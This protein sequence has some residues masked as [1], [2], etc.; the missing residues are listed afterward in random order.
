V[1]GVS[2]YP[3]SQTTAGWYN[4]AAFVEAPAGTFGNAGRDD[5]NAPPVFGFDADL[6]KTWTMPYRDN[7][8]VQLRVEAFNVLNHPNWG[9]PN[10]NIL[11]GAAI[12][13]AP[14]NAA[15]A[16]FGIIS[17]LAAGTTMRQLQVAM[18]YTF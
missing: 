12:A 15:H 9:G 4:R 16:G 7:H 6:H 5:V 10:G 11:A 18:K 2:P 1:I 8:R 17:S 3:S 14:A 13:G